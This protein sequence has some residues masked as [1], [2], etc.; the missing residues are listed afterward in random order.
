MNLLLGRQAAKVSDK[1]I[2]CT[3]EYQKYMAPNSNYVLYDTVGLSEGK[4]G[5]VSSDVAIK[6]L[7]GLLRSLS[8]GVSLL[9]YVIKKDRIRETTEK[10]YHLFVNA[11]CQDRV[12]VIL[13][14]TNLELEPQVESW[15]TSNKVHFDNYGMRFSDVISGTAADPNKTFPEIAPRIERLRAETKAKLERSIEKYALDTPWRMSS[16]VSWLNV[17]LA[18]T[19]NMFCDVFGWNSKKAPMIPKLK[20]I[21]MEQGN[22]SEAEATTVANTI[23]E[24]LL[25]RTEFNPVQEV[26]NL[27]R[28]VED[29]AAFLTQTVGQAVG[30]VGGVVANVGE[31]VGQGAAALARN[32]F[33]NF[34]F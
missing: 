19:W 18:K 33:S 23:S 31:A 29:G 5:Q 32:V 9:I 20:F 6:Q 17:I 13:A 27:G 10:N 16:W 12:P 24:E 7:I 2:G 15:W 30:N 34:R 3:F 25:G 28:N 8:E 26:A 11:I 14:I 22:M 4:S 1:A 21:L